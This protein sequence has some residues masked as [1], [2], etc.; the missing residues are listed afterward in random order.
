MQVGTLLIP[1]GIMGLIGIL[2]VPTAF[3]ISKEKE[4]TPTAPQPPPQ[5][6]Q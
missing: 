6:P 1:G 3:I 4:K 5:P 2:L